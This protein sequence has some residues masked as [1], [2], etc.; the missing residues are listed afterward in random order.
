MGPLLLAASDRPH[1]LP[2]SC[3]PLPPAVPVAARPLSSAPLPVLQRVRPVPARHLA[4][5]AVRRLVPAAVARGHRQGWCA[6]VYKVRVAKNSRSFI[7][8]SSDT[9]NY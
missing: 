1:A 5:L 2:G 9:C 3:L 8:V 4:G 7:K 6:G